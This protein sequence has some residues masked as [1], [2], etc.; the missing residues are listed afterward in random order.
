MSI[1]KN[2]LIRYK[3]LDRCF[4][5]PGKRYFIED[6]VS[7]CNK[8]LIEIDPNSRGVQKRQV[9]E[10][11]KYMESSE[12]WSVQIERIAFGKRKY[13]RYANK[14]FSIDNQPLNAVEI[15]HLRSAMAIISRFKGMPQ[16]Q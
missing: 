14:N 1:N 5:N 11:I 6:L 12:G 2:A 9:F 3:I 4:G 7:E 15:E 13:Y 16:F 8:Q 10:D